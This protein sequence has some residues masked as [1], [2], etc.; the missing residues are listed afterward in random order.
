MW[1]GRGLFF[2]AMLPLL[3]F[4]SAAPRVDATMSRTTP[5]P[6][7][8]LAAMATPS[9]VCN[10]GGP[11]PSATTKGAPAKRSTS[12]PP[13]VALPTPVLT[14]A[15]I[16]VEARRPTAGRTQT[17]MAVNETDVHR[18][19][20][21]T[22]TDA[23]VGL[24]GVQIAKTGPWAATPVLRGMSGNRVQVQVDG[25][26]LNLARGHG[27]QPSLV[28]ASDVESVELAM[29]ATSSRN[30]SGGMGGTVNIRTLS[31]LFADEATIGFAIDGRGGYPGSAAGAG[32]RGAYRSPSIGFEVRTGAGRLGQLETAEGPVDNSGY[33]E[34][35]E[36]VRAVGKHKGFTADAEYAYSQVT[37]AGLPAF[38]SPAGGFAS[39]PL[40]S[41]R[42]VRLELEQ[43]MSA[44]SRARVLSSWQE[45][46]TDF[47]ETT[48]DSIFSPL[49][50]FLGT[51][52][53][54]SADRIDTDAWSIEPA[55]EFGTTRRLKV[56][57]QLAGQ[58]SAGPRTTEITTRNRQ[59]DVTGVVNGE[60]ENVPPSERTNWSV[61]A[62]AEVPFSW[63]RFEAAFR[64][65]HF[66]SHADSTIYSYQPATTVDEERRTF[67]LGAA[68]MFGALG[69]AGNVELFG[70]AGT[71]FRAPGLDERFFN[72]YIH[73]GLRL[74]GN[75]DLVPET[76]RNFEVGVRA[77][78]PF[79]GRVSWVRASV[80]RAD[81]DDMITLRYLGQLYLQPRFEYANLDNARM[82]GLE[83][84]TRV[85]I[86]SAGLTFYASFPTGRD[87]DTGEPINTVG[88]R[89]I[90]ADF[91]LPF[92]SSRGLFS[93][94]AR[95][96]GPIDGVDDEFDR[97]AYFTASTS[98]QWHLGPF[99]AALS[100][101][102]LFDAY[103]FESLSAI[104][105]PGRTVT[106][107][108]RSEWET[109]MGHG[110][111]SSPVRN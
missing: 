99:D 71:G 97:D 41:R 56:F 82:E 44:Q 70:S 40:S 75:R 49:G 88:S 102:N 101:T 81:I 42:V 68:H 28:S 92:A 46:E 30:G 27:A 6:Q 19:I 103:Y 61:G 51:N 31:N 58:T 54:D 16:V 98:V 52:T 107:A 23:L 8:R 7:D 25:V 100:V 66:E 74:F 35:N 111:A 12:T 91:A 63:A 17:T 48:V 57:G 10:V 87:L 45:F 93:F 80:Y 18:Y 47:D 4:R 104:P 11:L 22:V 20:P 109:L 29:G 43:H 89:Q 39:F 15:P 65:D 38:A 24:P 53:N 90:S 67:S 36:A 85:P 73:G 9:S 105:E 21:T 62:S 84:E 108:I 59:G 78:S 33:S 34:R 64:S 69:A 5:R 2:A 55:A 110:H 26:G 50:R 86:Y 60:G 83:F 79:W 106:I 1:F 32:L 77:L 76:S 13:V 95:H 14:L 96:S 94:R 72:G 37:D 3:A